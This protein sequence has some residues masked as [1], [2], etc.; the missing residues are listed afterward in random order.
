VAKL[1][2][3]DSTV[4]PELLEFKVAYS[5]RVVS[6]I[7]DIVM[8][9][10]VPDVETKIRPV[11]SFVYKVTIAGNTVDVGAMVDQDDSNFS[12]VGL[13]GVFNRDTDPECTTDLVASY[14]AN[15]RQA[16]LT[17]PVAQG[18]IL[19]VE[20]IYA[21]KIGVQSFDPDFIEVAKVPGMFFANVQEQE[22]SPSGAD[23]AVVNKSDGSAIVVPAPYRSNLAITVIIMTGS[24]KDL[25]RLA[26][27]LKGYAE[28]NPVLKSAAIDEGYR[29]FLRDEFSDISAPGQ[30]GVRVAQATFTLMNVSV[31]KRPARNE[32]SVRSIEFGG[33]VS[34]SS[35]SGQPPVG[36]GI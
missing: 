33:D 31:W 4:T 28:N 6:F 30:A 2:T 3:S 15:A 19:Q 12:V 34:T 29:F 22:A 20:V 1:R 24:G 11:A 16:T 5:A 9:S 10:L 25:M 26:E 27:E 13:D 14:D 32:T 21:P 36:D 23:D 35:G 17:S 7:E 8:R 18:A